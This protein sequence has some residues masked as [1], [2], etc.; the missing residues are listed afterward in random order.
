LAGFV[1]IGETF[2]MAIV[3]EVQEEAGI[4]VDRS[5]IRC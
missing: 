4:T 5:S 2:E 3:R 1:E